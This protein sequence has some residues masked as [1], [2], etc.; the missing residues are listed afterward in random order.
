[1]KDY[2][3]AY[4]SFY[5]A[6]VKSYV[7]ALS[8][9]VP[10]FGFGIDANDLGMIGGL[11]FFVI[12][13]MYRFSLGREINNLEIAREEASRLGQ[14]REFYLVLAMRQVFTVPQAPHRE[15][16]WFL[17]WAPKLL[18]CVP[19][20]VQSVVTVNDVITFDVADEISRAHNIA[21]TIGELLALIG[22]LSLTVVAFKKL[23]RL[24]EVWDN[25]WDPAWRG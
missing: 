10:T 12:L 6:M 16:S 21:T 14:A 25:W 4:V 13:L 15:R 23:R 7:E 8:T 20:L 19:L 3:R 11:G 2:S 18:C 1:M 9:K 5:D 17:I 22:I 24:D